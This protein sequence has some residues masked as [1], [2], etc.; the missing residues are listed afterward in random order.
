MPAAG[1]VE[2]GGTAE[3]FGECYAHRRIAAG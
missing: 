1:V 3:A 2:D